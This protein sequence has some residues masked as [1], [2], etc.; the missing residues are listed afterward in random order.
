MEVMVGCTCE[1]E[2]G[3]RGQARD[4]DLSLPALR[5]FYP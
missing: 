4:G 3:R 2:I 5:L 1:I